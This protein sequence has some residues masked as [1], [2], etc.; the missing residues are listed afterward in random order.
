METTYPPIPNLV[1]KGAEIGLFLK[2]RPA[3]RS[4]IRDQQSE[5]NNQTSL[6]SGQSINLGLQGFHQ[7]FKGLDKFDDAVFEEVCHGC[8]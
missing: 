4:T 8:I 2:M 6:D 5:I 3:I 1:R 7:G